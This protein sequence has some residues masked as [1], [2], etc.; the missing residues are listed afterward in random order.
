MGVCQL[1]GLILAVL[2]YLS[3]E[4]LSLVER[5]YREEGY[6]RTIPG[7]KANIAKYKLL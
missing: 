3:R 2:M 4:K 5:L 6:T 1:E 7:L